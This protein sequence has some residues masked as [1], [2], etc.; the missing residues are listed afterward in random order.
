M[1]QTLLPLGDIS[2]FDTGLFSKQYTTPSGFAVIISNIVSA[3]TIFAGLA[4]LF[5]FLIGAFTWITGDNTQQLDK[6]KSQMST[7]IVGLIVVILTIPVAYII[8]KLTG[9]DIL[10]PELIIQKLLPN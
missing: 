2:G 4:F 3:I 5:W 1:N 6:A 9:L 10:N 8:G 7:A